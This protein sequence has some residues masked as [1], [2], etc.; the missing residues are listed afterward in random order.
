M[1]KSSKKGY[2]LVE[3]M[4]VIVIIG[5]LSTIILPHMVKGRYQAQ[6]TSCQGNLR[7]LA[8]ALEIYHTNEGVYPAEGNW[9]EEIFRP[10]GKPQYMHPEPTCP[11]NNSLYGYTVDDYDYHNFT[12]HCNGIHHLIIRAVQPGFPQYS[13]V[14]GLMLD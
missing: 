8:A 5:I 1:K 10:V 14:Q 13:T 12:T 4:I 9:R 6:F 3:M 11:S 2:T 7:N